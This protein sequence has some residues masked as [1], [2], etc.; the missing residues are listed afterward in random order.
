MWP[1]DQCCDILAKNVA[2]FRPCLKSLPEATLKSLGSMVVAKDTSKQPNIDSAMWLVVF[3]PMKIYNQKEHAGQV[4]N[5][6]CIVQGEMSIRKW[7]GA[8]SCVLTFSLNYTAQ[9][10]SFD[11]MVLVSGSK[12]KEKAYGISLCD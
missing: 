4:K 9:L 10:G 12:T 11:H 8:K 7:N 3:T 6:N 5:T 1:G 2:A